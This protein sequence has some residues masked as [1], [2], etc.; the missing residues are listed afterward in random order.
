MSIESLCRPFGDKGRIFCTECCRPQCF[1]LS[2]SIGGGLGGCLAHD[3][4]NGLRGEFCRAVTCWHPEKLA[5]LPP[6]KKAKLT[7]KLRALP[8]GKYNPQQ[9]LLEFQL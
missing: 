7:E 2:S 3:D 1:N 8:P 4:P 9:I 6:E 5:A